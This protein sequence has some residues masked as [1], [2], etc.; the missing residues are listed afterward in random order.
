MSY[1]IAVTLDR[2]AGD[3]AGTVGPRLPAVGIK[4]EHDLPVLMKTI[5]ACI[6]TAEGKD[7]KTG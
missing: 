5:Q 1:Q 4:G 7:S 3:G 6:D 2:K